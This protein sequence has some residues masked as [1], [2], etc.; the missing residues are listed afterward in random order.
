[1]GLETGLGE[2]LRTDCLLLSEEFTPAQRGYLERTRGFVRDEVLPVINGYW[3]R[4]EFPWPLARKLGAAGLAGDGIAGYGCPDLDPLPAGLVTMELNRGDGSLGTFLGVQAGL[5]MRPIA[6]LGSEAQERRWLPAMAAQR[7]SRF[8]LL[9]HSHVR[10]ATPLC[11][12]GGLWRKQRAR[13]V[14]PVLAAPGNARF[15]AGFSSAPR[16]R[17]RIGA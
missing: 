10:R 4:A 17:H 13:D 2:A 16:V 6:M 9:S 3:E 5:A 1:M 8:L 12:R 7:R 14:P 11:L 15:P